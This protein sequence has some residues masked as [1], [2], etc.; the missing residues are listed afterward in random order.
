[1]VRIIAGAARGRRLRAPEGRGTRPT[2]DR[3][4]EAV[5]SSLQPVLAGAHVLD[6]YAGS[7]ALGL[8]AVSRGATR[9]TAVESHR[10][11]LA[12]LAHNIEV[13]GVGEVEV[14]ADDVRRALVRP[15]PGAPFDVALLDPPYR[16][17]DAELTEVLRA[18]APHL[19]PG[20]VVIV[21][22][23][24]RDGEVPW[25]PD[26]LPERTRRY[27]DTAVHRGRAGST[28]EGEEST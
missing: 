16:T 24:A 12:A 20:A 13:V 2:A 4:K 28:D 6:L 25:P 23:A 26:L 1:M 15:L 18:L 3:V 17:G 11:A 7:G 22:R 21:E 9:L 19:A 10:S 8:E 27:G 14:V 5:F